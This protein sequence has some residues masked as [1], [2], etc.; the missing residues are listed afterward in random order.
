V[1]RRPSAPRDKHIDDLP[2]LVDRSVEVGPA[3]GDLDVGL[4]DEPPVDGCVSCWAGGV[5][6]LGSE[7]LHPAADR[8]VVDLDVTLGQQLF[9]VTVGLSVAQIPAH[10]H[11]DHLTGTDSRPV[12]T[13]QTSN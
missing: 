7:G 12:W 1:L 9:H 5:D 4:V 8:H 3:A 10:R 11:G 6:E 13:R 2:V